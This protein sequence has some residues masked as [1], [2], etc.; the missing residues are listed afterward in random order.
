MLTPLIPQTGLSLLMEKQTE[1]SAFAKPSIPVAKPYFGEAEEQAIIQVLRSGWVTQGP[2]VAEFEQSFAKYVGAKHAIAVSSC[3]TALHLCLY[4]LG[5]GPGDEVICPSYSFIATANVIVHCGAQPIFVDIDSQTYN[6]DPAL[7]PGAITSRTK[8]ILPVHQVGIPAPMQEILAV[9][10]HYN[11]PV[12]EDAA[13][14][15]GS[16]YCG[17][18][19]GKPIGVVACFSFHPRKIMTTGDGGMITTNDDELAARLKRLR[20]HAMST[21]DMVR[22]SASRVV[23]ETYNEV[24]YNYRMTDIQAA[25]GIEQLNRLPDFLAKRRMQ[26]VR[27]TEAFSQEEWLEPPFVPEYATP[28][29]QS[30]ILKIKSPVP[31]MRDK[32]MDDL[33][34]RGIATR[35]GVICIHREKAYISQ[36]LQWPLSESELATDTTITLPLYHTMTIEEQDTVISSIIEMGR[37]I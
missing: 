26:A 30:Y 16:H 19:I 2:L 1:M 9:A 4:A 11:L 7:I 14:A 15:I 20:Q 28:N 35:R 3:T 27:Y 37:T 21:S 5:I 6:L 12:I 22:H 8:A 33:L 34:R 13:C 29:F 24:G 10:R 18:L 32:L 23:F 31:N 25:I 17:E 36:K